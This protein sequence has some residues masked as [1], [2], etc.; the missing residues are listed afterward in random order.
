MLSRI[1]L[2]ASRSTSRSSSTRMLIDINNALTAWVWVVLVSWATTMGETSTGGSRP[3]LHGRRLRHRGSGPRLHVLMRLALLAMLIVL[4]PFASLLWVLPQTQQWTRWWTDMFVITVFQQAVQIMVL[5][6]GTALMVE[7]TPG[8]VSNAL[9]TML[10]G[11]AVCWLTLKV[12]SLLRSARSQAGITNVLTFAMATHAL[13]AEGR[14]LAAG[15]A[16]A[17]SGGGWQWW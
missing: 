8:S 4:G 13:G 9:L 3:R 2:A 11:L 10:L 6:L 7:L 15:A 1:I 17:W 16:G 14:E 5:A 12:P